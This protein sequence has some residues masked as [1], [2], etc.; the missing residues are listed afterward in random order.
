MK[1][2]IL[3]LI[4]AKINEKDAVNNLIVDTREIIALKEVYNDILKLT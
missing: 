2:K 4:L 3:E 1:T